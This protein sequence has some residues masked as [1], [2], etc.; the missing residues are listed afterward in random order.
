MLIRKLPF[1]RPLQLWHDAD[2]S[3]LS[4][5][6]SVN[7]VTFISTTCSAENDVTSTTSSSGSL[8]DDSVTV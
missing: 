4:K 8:L 1:A 2:L 7:C 6:G 5:L 3:L